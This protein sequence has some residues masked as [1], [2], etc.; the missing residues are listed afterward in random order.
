MNIAI[1][2]STSHIAKGLISKFLTDGN[3]HLHL[4]TRRPDTVCDFIN[5]IGFSNKQ[6]NDIHSDYENFMRLSC[7]VI[8]N[9]VGLGPINKLENDYTRYFTITE[10]YDNLAI[11][12]LLKKCSNALYISF[13]SG[14][15]Y[16]RDFSSPCDEKSIRSILIN[17]IAKEDYYSIARLNAEAKHRAFKN[18]NI[19]D[20]RIFSYFSRFID[21]TDFYFIT[22]LLKAVLNKSVFETSEKDFIRDYLHPVDLY[23]AVKKCISMHQI[24]DAFDISSASPVSKQEILAYFSGTYGLKYKQSPSSNFK[25]ATGTKNKYYS[26]S[27]HASKIGYKPKYR[28]IDTIQ[29]EAKF[30]LKNVAG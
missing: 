25:S 23:G 2:G 19:V 22:E 4:F 21:L 6:R 5:S 8:I 3:C 14:S 30:I 28:S 27:I 18:L 29:E 20:L 11:N 7:D 1:L 26:N 16:G 15:I 9:C 17:G 13:S 12:C 10:K 24:N